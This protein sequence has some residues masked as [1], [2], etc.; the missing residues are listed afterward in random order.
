M[1]TFIISH[2]ALSRETGF[3]APV[4][5]S[6]GI[7]VWAAHNPT[8]PDD[9]TAP[10]GGGPASGSDDVLEPRPQALGAGARLDLEQLDVRQR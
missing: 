7:G 1:G 2:A 6:A 8:L 5:C 10:Q 3:A 4:R 9:N